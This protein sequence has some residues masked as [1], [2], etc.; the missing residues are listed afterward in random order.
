MLLILCP[1]VA[2]RIYIVLSFLLKVTNQ[3]NL[4]NSVGSF[5]QS[6]LDWKKRNGF[7]YPLGEFRIR[8]T[9]G[10]FSV[11][12]LRIVTEIR[13]LLTKYVRARLICAREI[14]QSASCSLSLFLCFVTTGHQWSKRCS[15]LT[16]HENLT[17]PWNN[18]RAVALTSFCYNR[19]PKHFGSESVL[20]NNRHRLRRAVLV[21][22]S[23]WLWC[24]INYHRK[25]ALW[26][27]HKPMRLAVS[28]WFFLC[29]ETV[30][31]HANKLRKFN[32]EH[33]YWRSNHATYTTE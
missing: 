33:D 5:F 13:R 6:T 17:G 4:A 1:D 20:Q 3:E 24:I 22:R 16:V 30:D 26:I 25:G 15:R 2:D 23:S 18:L 7:S 8:K 32:G 31:I 14:L 9:R 21:V 19:R 28:P 12:R 11:M 10:R 29:G 27:G